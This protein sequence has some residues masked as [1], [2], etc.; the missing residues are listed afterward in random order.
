MQY[1][2][3]NKLIQPRKVFEHP[4][5]PQRQLMAMHRALDELRALRG[6]TPPEMLAEVEKEIHFYEQ[7]LE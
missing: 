4:S 5:T 7:I 2:L 6:S 1:E 3:L